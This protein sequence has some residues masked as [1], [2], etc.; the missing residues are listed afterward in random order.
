MTASA[1]FALGAAVQAVV[2]VLS[3][4]LGRRH[5]RQAILKRFI[6]LRDLCQASGTAPEPM[7]SDR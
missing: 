4:D 7:T 6:A 1:W 5:G 2:T 3:Y